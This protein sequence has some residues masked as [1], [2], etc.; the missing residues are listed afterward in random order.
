MLF[1][2]FQSS[3]FTKCLI[4][5]LF[6]HYHLFTVSLNKQKSYFTYVFIMYPMNS[7]FQLP[8]IY[9]VIGD[10][11]LLLVLLICNYTK[12]TQ[13]FI[14]FKSKR[15]ETMVKK[16]QSF[17][18]ELFLKNGHGDIRAFC[19]VD[20]IFGNWFVFLHIISIPTI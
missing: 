2:Y 16:F 13:L 4:L 14:V 6:T 15:C 20:L 1:L 19:L 7:I 10:G 5:I 17:N 3:L 18:M 12:G 8:T 11:I 9:N